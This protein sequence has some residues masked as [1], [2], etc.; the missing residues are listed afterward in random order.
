MDVYTYKFTTIASYSNTSLLTS[1]PEERQ[2]SKGTKC[3][4]GGA[5]PAM[6]RLGLALLYPDII[7]LEED[8]SDIVNNIMFTT[9][10]L[11]V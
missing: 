7:L 10:N 11:R 2:R 9:V 8:Y 6:P 5:L 1:G 3:A 4:S